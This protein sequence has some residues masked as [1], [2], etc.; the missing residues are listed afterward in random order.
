MGLVYRHCMWCN[1][2]FW[3]HKEIQKF[4]SDRCRNYFTENRKHHGGFNVGDPV[5]EKKVYYKKPTKDIIEKY[6]KSSII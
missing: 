5:T 2:I 4:C 6:P 3:Q 1:G